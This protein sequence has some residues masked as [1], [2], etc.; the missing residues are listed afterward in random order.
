M[1]FKRRE[2]QPPFEDHPWRRSPSPNTFKDDDH[3]LDGDIYY[4]LSP[5]GALP[6]FLPPRRSPPKSAPKVITVTSSSNQALPRQNKRGEHATFQ[7]T[8]HTDIHGQVHQMELPDTER[9]RYSPNFKQAPPPSHSSSPADPPQHPSHPQPSYRLD[10]RFDDDEFAYTAH[11]ILNRLHEEEKVN[12]GCHGDFLSIMRFLSGAGES[13]T[14]KP[15]SSE[16]CEDRLAEF[17]FALKHR[18][19][20]I[21]PTPRASEDSLTV[22][23]RQVAKTVAIHGYPQPVKN[24]DKSEHHDVDVHTSGMNRM[25]IQDDEPSSTTHDTGE[26]STIASNELPVKF[27]HQSTEKASPEPR[28]F[29]PSDEFDSNRRLQDETVEEE[30]RSP[31]N[32][33]STEYTPSPTL[34]TL[35]GR[36]SPAPYD[37]IRQQYQHQMDQQKHQF[38]RPQAWPYHDPHHSPYDGRSLHRRRRHHL[39]SNG[40]AIFEIVDAQ[41]AFFVPLDAYFDEPT[42][43]EFTVEPIDFGPILSLEPTGVFE[44]DNM[45]DSNAIYVGIDRSFEEDAVVMRELKRPSPAQFP[46]LATDESFAEEVIVPSEP[47]LS[48]L[49]LSRLRQKTM[50][51]AK[52]VTSMINLTSNPSVKESCRHRLPELQEELKLMS[53]ALQNSSS[54]SLDALRQEVI[55]QNNTIAEEEKESVQLEIKQA[56]V[57]SEDITE[58]VCK[59]SGP[60]SPPRNYGLKLNHNESDGINANLVGRPG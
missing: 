5:N 40:D 32:T 49:Q 21:S 33:T 56:N 36:P 12:T 58:I 54:S 38:P 46:V 9:E 52:G 43:P 51:E 45:V 14:Q 29:F 17:R 7:H 25:E 57:R 3:D 11:L 13:S 18:L 28:F 16:L 47:L 31:P 15:T 39:E 53:L 34:P 1:E 60:D 6:M 35:H 27:K 41:P 44:G 2:R 42:M 50:A 8:D 19:K 10:M 23:T 59:R 22:L 37:H 20:F 26:S 24:T 48:P 4:S 55:L 30:T